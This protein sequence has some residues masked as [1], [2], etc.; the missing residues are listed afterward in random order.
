MPSLRESIIAWFDFLREIKR[1][2][3]HGKMDRSRVALWALINIFSANSFVSGYYC[4]VTSTNL[5]TTP[6]VLMAVFLHV[7]LISEKHGFQTCKDLL[8]C[9]L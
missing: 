1:E 9:R 8:N 7:L 3:E 5:R 4:N 6:N 2:G